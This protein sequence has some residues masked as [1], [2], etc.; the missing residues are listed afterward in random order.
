[1]IAKEIKDLLVA[2][3]R[4]YYKW[5][6]NNKKGRSEIDVYEIKSIKDKDIYSLKLDSQLFNLDAILF[7][8]PPYN[9]VYDLSQ[10]RIHEYD[11]DKRVLLVKPSEEC[12]INLSQIEAKDVRIISDLKFLIERLGK[13]YERKGDRIELPTKIPDPKFDATNFDYL[14]TATPS[15]GQKIALNTVFTHSLSYIWGA[16]GTGKTRFV[17]SNSLLKYIQ[18]GK[19]VIIFAPTNV[20]LEQVMIGVLEVIDNAGV[21]REKILRI[22]HPSRKFAQ[23]YPEVCEV[24]G[25]DRQIQQLKKQ[26]Q[27]LK[28]LLGIS[29]VAIDKKT[30]NNLISWRNDRLKTTQEITIALDGLQRLG[31]AAVQVSERIEH[32][33]DVLVVKRNHILAYEKNKVSFLGSLVTIFSPKYYNNKIKIIQTSIKTIEET[34]LEERNKQNQL[35]KNINNYKAQLQKSK[36]K[37]KKLESS[38]SSINFLSKELQDV[39][40]KGESEN[41][42]TLRDLIEAL[43][44]NIEN[45]SMLENEY[46]KYSTTDL[47]VKLNNYAQELITLEAQSIYERIK[48]VNVVGATLDGFVSRYIERDVAFEHVFIDEAAYSNAAK[49]LVL[50]TLNAPITLLGD[51]MQLPPVAEMKIEELEGEN[52][53][54]FPFL[55][56]ALQSETFFH[57]TFANLLSNSKLCKP[58]IFTATARADLIETHRFG[59]NLAEVLNRFVYKNGFASV[60]N[61]KNTEII[62]IHADKIPGRRKRENPKEALAIQEYILKRHHSNT[63]FA[64]LSPYNYQVQLIGNYLIEARNEQKIMTVHKSQGQEWDTV[65]LSLSDTYDMWFTNSNNTQSNAINLINTA[66]SRAKKRLVIVCDTRYWSSQPDQFIC[67]LLQAGN[68]ESL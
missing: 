60:S 1:M 35:I 27:I 61:F 30:F 17:L 38:I 32:N 23:K 14:V 29:D 34:L 49:A 39:W 67:G 12:D 11:Y 64:I 36:L 40:Q 48:D 63:D 51:H 22:G 58:A 2:S 53:V 43:D 47:E 18:D 15:I 28:G 7:E 21:E 57:E 41:I 52:E 59:S 66:V 24:A 65:I 50:F 26:I 4:Q 54:C 56:S 9:K 16:P 3:C 44:K 19:R 42:D 6:E 25:I 13:Y 31:N 55:Q 46:S 5:M 20:A 37:L 68:I 33:T 45:S 10:I 8:F 62:I